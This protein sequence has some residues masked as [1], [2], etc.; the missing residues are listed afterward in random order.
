MPIN[1]PRPGRAKTPGKAHPFLYGRPK[2]VWYP[3]AVGVVRSYP[4][5]QEDFTRRSND[6][7]ERVKALWAAGK[8]KTRKGIPDGFAGKAAKVNQLKAK[9]A[10]E[11]RKILAVMKEQDLIDSDDIGDEAMLGVLQMSRDTSEGK[12]ERLAALKT[13][14][15]YTKPKPASTSKVELTRPEDFLDELLAASKE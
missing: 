9:A 4:K 5:T 11:A 2:G 13:V 1:A 3:D 6:M 7:R 15:E 10:I 8:M 12:R 14:L